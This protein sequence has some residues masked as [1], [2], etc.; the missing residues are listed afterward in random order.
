MPWPLGSSPISARVSGSTPT[1]MNSDRKLLG[2]VEHAERAVARVGELG[3]RLDDA[4]Q[5]G[6][7]VEVAADRRPRHGAAAEGSCGPATP[8]SGTS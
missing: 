7:E 1:V 2:R 4:L 6:G 5:R 8:P 3:G